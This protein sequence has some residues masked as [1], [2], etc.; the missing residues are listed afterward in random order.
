MIATFAGRP[1]E[2]IG[3][4]GRRDRNAVDVVAGVFVRLSSHALNGEISIGA[5]HTDDELVLAA[6]SEEL[7]LDLDSILHVDDRRALC[8]LDLR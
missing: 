4:G 1:R 3:D 2:P 6:G 7:A 8:A 5:K